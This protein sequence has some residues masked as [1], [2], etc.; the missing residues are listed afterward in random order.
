MLELLKK[1]A[2][3]HD[4]PTEPGFVP[5]D[6]R[7]AIVCDG[8]G[9]FLDVVELGDTGAKRNPGYTFA[10]CPEFSFPE[11]KAGGEI[12][13]HFLVETAGVVALHGEDAGDAKLRPKH[14]YFFKLLREAGKVMPELAAIA[15]RISGPETAKMIRDRMQELKI[16][17]TEKVTF[18]VGNIF[19]VESD[20]WHDW[21]R[22]CRELVAGTGAVNGI[23]KGQEPRM[24]CLITGDLYRPIPVHP[25]IK[26][27]ADVGGQ[28]AGDALI[29][30]KQESF[31]SYGLAQSFN[32]ACSEAAASVYRAAI[33]HIIK[34]SGHRLA[35][36]KVAYWFKK[37]VKPDDDP[38]PWLLEAPGEQE[39][40]AIQRA[41]H[42]MESIRRGV[43]SDLAE[44]YFYAFTLSGAAGRVMVRDWME[45]RFENLAG[46]I[47]LWFGDLEIVNRYGSGS[48][49]SPKFLAVLG[50]TVRDL[51]DLT[52]PFIANMWRVAVKGE[53]FPQAALTAALERTRIDIIQDEP[54]NHARM[55]LLKAYHVRKKRLTGGVSMTQDVQCHLNPEHPNPAYH[56]GRLMAVLAALQRRA[57][58]D[59]GAGVIQRY[60]AAA[61]ATP[62]LV[63]GRL[64]R[65]SQFHLG[66]LEP[67][68]AYW[69]EKIL[70][71][72][73]C[74]IKDNLPRTLDLEEQ[75][76]FALGYYQQMAELRAKKSDNSSSDKEEH[77]G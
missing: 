29:S 31:R 47:L 46:N 12:K 4:L 17:P 57:L 8:E 49:G 20:T 61:S 21:W 62:S 6:V 74:R 54:F 27:L 56:C 71:G 36:A 72:I 24:R 22:N 45:G 63:F 52:S 2:H 44:N 59:V 1:Y 11:M 43:R 25:K 9:R 33:N 58:G 70:S 16:K 39:I 10:R 65:T 50:A 28:P 66:K 60:Y 77:N 73:W 38:L 51:K 3:D 32:A 18:K 69:Y 7:W 34:E 64:V 30:F 23:E 76:L 19:P 48:A 13:S 41:R 14:E 5:K 67:G 75:S 37:K 53:I 40:T 68:L 35:G 55:G 42:L 15:G 26:G